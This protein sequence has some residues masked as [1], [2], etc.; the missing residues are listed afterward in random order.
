[1]HKYW[2]WLGLNLGKHAGIVSIV[3]LMVTIV[4]GFGITKL[5]FATGQ[6]SYLNKDDEVYKDSVAYQDL[7]GGQ[8]MITLVTLARATRPSSSLFTPEN[9]E[10][11]EQVEADLKRAARRPHL[12]VSSPRS[13]PLQFTDDLVLP[14]VGRTRREGRGGRHPP[15]R[16][17]PRTRPEGKA[18]RAEYSAGHPRPDQRDPTPRTACSATRRGTTFLL[19]DNEGGIRKALLAVLPRRAARPDGRAPRRATSSIEDEGDGGRLR[20]GHRRATSPSRAPTVTHHRRPGAAAG[21]Q[22]LPHAAAC[23][24]LGRHRRGPDDRHPAR[25]VRRAVAAAPARRR[26]SSA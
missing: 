3:G 21:R 5:E 22:R 15:R 10:K 9:I 25:A 16:R 7:F 2:S 12:S 23:S 8:A 13:P 24:T 19:Y 17:H 18:V 4:L 1:M 6:D 14:R 20:A 11:W 26:S